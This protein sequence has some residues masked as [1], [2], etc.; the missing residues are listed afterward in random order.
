VLFICWFCLLKY[1]F[2]RPLKDDG[3]IL[4]YNATSN[5]TGITYLSLGPDLFYDYYLLNQFADCKVYIAEVDEPGQL[6]YWDFYEFE[7]RDTASL[8]RSNRMQMTVVLAEKSPLS[9]WSR[10]PIQSHYREA[11]LQDLYGQARVLIAQ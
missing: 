2:Q 8:F 7:G 6:E 4:Q 11:S 9:T 10:M 3:R 1:F 5:F